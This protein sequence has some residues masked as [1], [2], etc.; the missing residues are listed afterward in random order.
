MINGAVGIDPNFTTLKSE[1]L[2]QS[3]N[4]IVGTRQ[5]GTPQPEDGQWLDVQE[6][7]DSRYEP[8]YCWHNCGHYQKEN[9]GRIVYGWRLFRH[10][11]GIYFAQHHAIWTDTLGLYV[12]VTPQE[13]SLPDNDPI[14]FAADGRIFIEPLAT[15]KRPTLF[16]YLAPDADYPEALFKWGALPPTGTTTLHYWDTPGCI[17]KEVLRLQTLEC[18]KNHP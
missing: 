4:Y 13:L 1:L 8:L 17:D 3:L 10:M 14:L 5:E 7:R 18:K 16:I 12:D 9:G 6:R 11:E 15:F 2:A